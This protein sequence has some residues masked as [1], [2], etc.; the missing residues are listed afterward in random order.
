LGIDAEPHQP[1]PE[2]IVELIADGNER[3]SLTQ[4]AATDPSIA[5][6][7]LLF[8]AK[9]SIYKAWFSL[10]GTWLDFTEC[11]LSVQAHNQ[12]FAGNL[13]IRGPNI[14]A[15]TIERFNGRWAILD[16]HIITA[17]WEPAP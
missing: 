17:V 2:G 16:H 8:S 14:G 5:W 3:R 12:T 9:E 13:L 15:R 10:A 4:L 7:R 1:L 11:E 6:D